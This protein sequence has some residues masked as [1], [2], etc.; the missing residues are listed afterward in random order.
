MNSLSL[1]KTLRKLVQHYPEAQC[2]LRFSSA[3]ELLVATILSAQCTDERVNK[4]TP[5][6]FKKLPT[7]HTV[8]VARIATIERLVR[9]AGFYKNKAKGIKGSAQRIVTTYNG[10]VPTTM[11][12]LLT[13]PGVARKTA[14]VVLGTAFHKA[15]GIVVDTHV[16]RIV[17]RFG[18]TTHANPQKIEQDLMRLLPQKEWILFS[19]RLI[20]HGRTLC[21]APTPVCSQCFLAQNCPKIGV[22]NKK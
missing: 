22:K 15:C 8:A 6:F 14:N 9:S 5:G 11:D 1:K 12:E 19:H 18:W 20:R 10:Q 7:V 21:K 17:R 2:S 4:I 16:S 13:L 3:W